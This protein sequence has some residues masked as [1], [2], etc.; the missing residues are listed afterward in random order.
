MSSRFYFRTVCYFCF[1]FIT[2]ACILPACKSRVEHL[3]AELNH[4]DHRIRLAAV[5][6]LVE[7][8]DE[9]ADSLLVY[10]FADENDAVRREAVRSIVQRIHKR[11]LNVNITDPEAFRQRIQTRTTYV[12][13]SL[14]FL[15]QYVKDKDSYVIQF[16][17]LIIGGFMTYLSS[18]SYADPI[19]I[20]ALRDIRTRPY[21]EELIAKEKVPTG[22]G[23]SSPFELSEL[24]DICEECR[25]LIQH[26]DLT[27][28]PTYSWKDTNHVGTPFSLQKGIV[29]FSPGSSGTSCASI[30]SYSTN[31]FPI[32]GQPFSVLLITNEREVVVGHYTQGGF[33]VNPSKGKAVSTTADVIVLDWPE[34]KIVGVIKSVYAPPPLFQ[35]HYGDNEG[36]V[37]STLCDWI[38]GCNI[39]LVGPFA[40][41]LREANINPQEIYNGK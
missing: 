15:V 2:V 25:N 5:S 7:L 41:R 39:Y 30:S 33:P 32:H 16:S 10:M 28:H 17:F 13:E 8:D 24:R 12:L 9:R 6:S 18:R 21:A 23:R 27:K 3:E 4:E 20:D 34:K 31:S 11:G 35:K 26:A 40:A 22:P 14:A 1:C 38:R 37:G 29:I 36:S 19:L